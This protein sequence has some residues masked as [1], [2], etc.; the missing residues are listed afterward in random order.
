M[1]KKQ[2]SDL[3]EQLKA[4][5]PGKTYPSSVEITEDGK[6]IVFNLN[7]FFVGMYLAINVDGCCIHQGGDHNNKS[8]VRDL[9]SDIKKAILRGATVEIGSIRNVK[10]SMDD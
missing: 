1:N 9:K 3:T 4:I 10:T 7:S 2:I 8:I 5:V 6:K